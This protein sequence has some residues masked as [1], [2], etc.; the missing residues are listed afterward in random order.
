MHSL[1]ERLLIYVI[2]F[3]LL[4]TFIAGIASYG[5]SFKQIYEFLVIKPINSFLLSIRNAYMGIANYFISVKEGTKI[6]TENEDL[7]NQ[8]AILNGRLKL[9]LGYYYENTELKNLLGIKTKLNFK[10]LGSSV[11]FYDRLS[12]FF[13]ID[14]GSKDGVK[15]KMPVVYSTDGEN[16]VLIGVVES[17]ENNTS[18]VMLTI[19]KDFKIGVKN[20]SRGGIDVAE[21]T[22]SDLKISKLINLSQDAIN[23]YFATTE[24]SDIYPPNI[25]VGKLTNIERVSTVELNLTLTPLVNFYNIRNVLVIT[26]YEKK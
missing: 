7:K 9:L 24:L 12:N 23:D 25:F 4:L 10:T 6:I 15:A 3:V 16:A 22:G 19:N 8:I 11:I 17:V 20:V 26:S 21:G 18:K 13:V 2:V 14:V 1:K 5:I